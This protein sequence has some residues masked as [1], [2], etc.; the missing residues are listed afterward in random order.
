[1]S[2]MANGWNLLNAG[3][4][5]GPV[6]RFRAV[7]APMFT[8][9]KLRD[10]GK[11]RIV[12]SPMAQYMAVDGAPTDWHL[13]HYGERA[14]GGAGLVC[15][16]MTCVSAESRIT[17]GCPGLYAPEHEAA[18]R[19]LADFVHQNTD[20]RSVVRSVILVGKAQQYRLGRHGSALER[21]N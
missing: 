17:P 8:P 10:M 15:V 3:S 9:F 2:V 16:E 1:M 7:R 14:K 18:W 4:C 11:N 20:A 5:S 12:V 6:C 13:T 21:W 19:R